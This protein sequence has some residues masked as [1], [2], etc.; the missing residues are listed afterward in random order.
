LNTPTVFRI[1]L[2]TANDLRSVAE[3]HSKAVRTAY[4]EVLPPDVFDPEFVAP[5]KLEKEYLA[6]IESFGPRDNLLKATAGDE[7]VGSCACGDDSELNEQGTGYLQRV[8][9]DPDWWGRGVGSALVNRSLELLTEHGFPRA[10]LQVLENNKKASAFYEKR[11]W[12]FEKTVRVK[13][14]GTELRYIKRLNQTNQ[15]QSLA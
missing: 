6:L 5:G 7:I 3:V 9:V 14:V 4:P 2:A 1:E 12:Q 13:N 11:G 8:Y 10:A 15:T